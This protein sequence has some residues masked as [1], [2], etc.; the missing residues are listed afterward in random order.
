MNTPDSQS[1]ERSSN[2]APHAAA[3]DQQRPALAIAAERSL[4]L[5][6]ISAAL[7]AIV[8]VLV[9][10]RLVVLPVIAAV[11]LATALVP[12]ARWLGARRWPAALAALTTMG[13]TAAV[14]ATV[15]AAICG[16]TV[17]SVGRF[18]VPEVAGRVR[19]A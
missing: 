9:Q 5:L 17:A 16:P 8:F 11:F 15:M 6:L 14:F 13:M 10:L 3:A 7:T 19:R 1:S 12:T 18:T 4:Q 2:R